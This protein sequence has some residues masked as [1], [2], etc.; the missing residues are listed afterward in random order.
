MDLVGA[1]L[2][3]G[4][5]D[6]AVAAAEFG[7]VG[8]GFDLEFGDGVHRRLDHIRGAVKHVA[9][10]RIVVDAV[11]QEIVL[12]RARAVGA[13]AVCCFDARAGLGGSDADAEQ[14]EL[15]VVAAVQGKRVDALAV[16]HLAKVGGFGFELRTFAGDRDGFRCRAGLKLQVHADAILNVDLHRA[17]N[18][19]FESLSFRP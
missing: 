1:G 17:G 2:D 11:E 6:R 14:S 16:H 8:V 13:E 19:L 7:A 9:Q 5:H 18:R 4:V 3:D 10:I 15:R 12:Q